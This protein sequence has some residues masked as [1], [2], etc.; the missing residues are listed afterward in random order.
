MGIVLASA[1]RVI[2]TRCRGHVFLLAFVVCT[3][4]TVEMGVFFCVWISCRASCLGGVPVLGAAFQGMHV[5]Q[6]GVHVVQ[7][8]HVL[9]RCQDTMMYLRIRQGTGSRFGAWPLFASAL[10]F[11]LS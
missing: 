1:S 6:G 10:C 5:A 2:D 7:C 3:S 11:Q 4:G 8:M 9:A